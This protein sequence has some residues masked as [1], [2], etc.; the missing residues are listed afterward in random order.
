MSQQQENTEMMKENLSRIKRKY[1]VLSGKGGVGKSTV[2]VNLAATLN[3]LGKKVGILDVDIHG[4]SIAKMTGLSGKR[5]E[6]N[7]DGNPVPLKIRENFYVLTIAALLESDDTPV[8]WRG[9]LKMTAIKQFLNDI[10]WPELDYLIID[11]PPGTGDEPLSA[12]QLIGQV[13]GS[14]IVSTPQEVAFLDARKTINF[15][16]MLKVPVVGIVE[17]MSGFK[18]PKCGEVTY[19]FKSGGAE[20]AAKDFGVDILGK[21]PFEIEMVESGD[22][23]DFFVIKYPES[24]SAKVYKEIAEK[25]MIKEG[26]NKTESNMQQTNPCSSCNSQCSN[27]SGGEKMKVAV[28]LA[29]GM[30]C[31]HFGHAEQFGIYDVENG[32]IVNKELVTPP[33]HEPGIIPKWLNSLNVN[34]IIAGGMGSRA[35]QFFN[36][37]GIKVLVGASAKTP[38]SLIGEMV[39][40]T[41]QLGSNVCDH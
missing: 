6:M 8:V 29:N 16:K 9:P 35:Q 21:V 5:L 22:S 3:L 37:Y 40:G 27:S 18:C 12:V 11:C 17:N 14:I 25:I 10:Q 7:K 28:P 19:I 13:D 26:K 23:G 39:E 36:E 20:K 24:E 30:L 15:S 41:L 33:P 38:E 1:I 31:M 34:V 2:S 4:P 32:K